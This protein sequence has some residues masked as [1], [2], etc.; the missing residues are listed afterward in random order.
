MY[1]RKDVGLGFELIL[2]DVDG[3]DK[4][5]FIGLDEFLKENVIFLMEKIELCLWSSWR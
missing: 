2:G 3:D 4:V 5:R 1:E